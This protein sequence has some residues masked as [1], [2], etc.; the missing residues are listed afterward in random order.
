[1]S[2]NFLIDSQM[3][4]AGNPSL[5][6]PTRATAET[7]GAGRAAGSWNAASVE[8]IAGE[9]GEELER[10]YQAYFAVAATLADDR[11]VPAG[12]V[13]GAVPACGSIGGFRVT[14]QARTVVVFGD[15]RE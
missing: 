13:A 10:L 2:G 15:R 3:Q 14:E 1:V 8:L 9:A 6:D 5:I 12:T 7:G 11:A 4:L